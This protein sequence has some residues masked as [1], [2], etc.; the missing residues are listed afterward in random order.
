VNPMEQKT[1]F[2]FT[3][4]GE[5]FLRMVRDNPPAPPPSIYDRKH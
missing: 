2:E 1:G 4:D 3:A 5:T